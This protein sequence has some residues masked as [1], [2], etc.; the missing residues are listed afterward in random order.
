MKNCQKEHHLDVLVYQLEGGFR[1]L[2][3]FR[4]EKK[5]YLNFRT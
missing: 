1:S 2:S 3:N 4:L 5:N